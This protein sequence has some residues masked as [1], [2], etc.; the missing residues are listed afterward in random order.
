MTPWLKDTEGMSQS[1][2]IS[3]YLYPYVSDLALDY[4]VLYYLVLSN[5]IYSV[6]KSVSKSEIK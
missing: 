2:I 5:D 3:N 1:V 4:T 6:S